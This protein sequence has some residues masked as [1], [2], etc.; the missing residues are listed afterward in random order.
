MDLIVSLK[1]VVLFM[2][3]SFGFYYELG[4]IFRRFCTVFNIKDK[5][6]VQVDPVTREPI[7]TTDIKT[8][9]K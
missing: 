4:V 1:M 6:M 9:M 7:L 3:I 2:G 5:R 8:N